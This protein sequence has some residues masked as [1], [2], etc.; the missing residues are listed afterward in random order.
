MVNLLIYLSFYSH[1]TLSVFF[2]RLLYISSNSLSILKNKIPRASIIKV[3]FDLQSTKI[4]MVHSKYEIIFGTHVSKFYLFHFAPH[5]VITFTNMWYQK[6]SLFIALKGDNKINRKLTAIAFTTTIERA[7]QKRSKA[8]IT[9]KKLRRLNA[10]TLREAIYVQIN[11]LIVY[12]NLA[13][14]VYK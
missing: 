13:F 3:Q 1:L 10:I 8:L 2:F 11:N 6:L 14:L 7:I 5:L 4:S 9:K 12:Q